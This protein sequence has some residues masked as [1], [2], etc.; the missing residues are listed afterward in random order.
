MK[1]LRSPYA[2]IKLPDLRINSRF[3][4][5]PV[6]TFIVFWIILPWC[7]QS[8]TDCRHHEQAETGQDLL[9]G[10]VKIC[11]LMSGKQGSESNFNPYREQR[12]KTPRRRGRRCLADRRKGQP[13]MSFSSSSRLAAINSGVFASTIRRSSGSVFEARTLNHQSEYSEE[14]PSSS[15]M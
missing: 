13:R 2:L 14:M 8:S 7:R 15:N 3:T 12:K 10:T 6:L 1:T 11:P 9:H 4:V 5:R